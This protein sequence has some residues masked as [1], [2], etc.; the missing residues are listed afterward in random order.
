V[1]ADFS[2]WQIGFCQRL[3][4]VRPPTARLSHRDQQ[5]ERFVSVLHRPLAALAR[6]VAALGRLSR[7]FMTHPQTMMA[8]RRWERSFL[9]IF[10]T[11]NL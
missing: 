3:V 6:R 11:W 9:R 5:A 2:S 4:P 7:K 8:G 1:A 10:G